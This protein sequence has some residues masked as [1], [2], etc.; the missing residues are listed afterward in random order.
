MVSSWLLLLILQSPLLA[1][2]TKFE[3]VKK[4]V[5]ACFYLLSDKFRE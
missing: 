4:L 2:K 5:C 1:D 3:Q